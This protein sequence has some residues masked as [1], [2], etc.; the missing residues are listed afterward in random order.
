ML[1]GGSPV[2]TIGGGVV[3]DPFAPARS[4]GWHA[5]GATAVDSLRRLLSEAGTNGLAIPELPVRLGLPPRMVSALLAEAAAWCVQER[6][7]SQEARASIVEGLSNAV[8]QFHREHPLESGA[9]QQWLRSRLRAPQS[10]V[11]AVVDHLAAEGSIAVEQGEVRLASFAPTLSEPQRLLADRITRRLEE[12]GPEPPSLD[13]LTSELES[14]QRELSAVV[15]VLA[16][17]GDLVA[18]EPNRYYSP[19]AVTL[20]RDRLLCVIS[21]KG[22]VGPGEIRDLLGLTRKFVIPFLEYCDREGYTIRDGL[23]RRRQGT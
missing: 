21:Q 18:V 23:G 12:A 15:H 5:L 17:Q 19:A 3:T 11:D 6:A 1:R 7:Y 2:A 16:R 14:D 8:A 13:E 22:D 20:L 10:A 9:S 4:K